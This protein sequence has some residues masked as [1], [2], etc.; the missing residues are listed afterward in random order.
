LLFFNKRIFDDDDTAAGPQRIT[1]TDDKTSEEHGMRINREKT[2]EIRLSEHK[3]NKNGY[4]H[5]R[6]SS[7]AVQLCLSGKFNNRWLQM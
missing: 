4:C 2:K 5:R 1:D 3:R 7:W 6:Y